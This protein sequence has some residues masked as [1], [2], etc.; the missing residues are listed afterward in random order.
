MDDVILC[1]LHQR[2]SLPSPLSTLCS[3]QLNRWFPC[4]FNH[5]RSFM[6]TD[7]NRSTVRVFAWVKDWNDQLSLYERKWPEHLYL[8][9]H[10]WHIK[11][12]SVYSIEVET[13][14]QGFSTSQMENVRWK[15][16]ASNSLSK[17]ERERCGPMPS[18]SNDVIFTT[19]KRTPWTYIDYKILRCTW[20]C[21]RIDIW[22]L[23][24]CIDHDDHNVY[25]C[26]SYW[27]LSRRNEQR[28]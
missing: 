20:N 14:G 3:S 10:M 15:A 9:M 22:K 7:L 19:F 25:C 28:R 5:D 11:V 1:H 17:R 12:F 21:I 23:N 27:F 4:F 8:S 26:S 18:G 6:D 24:F 13:I 16:R 2:Y